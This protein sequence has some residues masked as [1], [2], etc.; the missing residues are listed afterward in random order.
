MH[1]EEEEKNP[2]S[3]LKPDRTQVQIRRTLLHKG[4]KANTG[5]IW[6]EFSFVKDKVKYSGAVQINTVWEKDNDVNEY[7]I[8]NFIYRADLPKVKPSVRLRK[9][10][11]N[12][13]LQKI[14]KC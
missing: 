8:K 9:Q 6:F 13:F 1:D 14:I 10:N 7:I 12:P 3:D 5:Y 4:K 2:K 11:K